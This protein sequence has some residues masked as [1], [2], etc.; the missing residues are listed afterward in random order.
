M[1][2]C[3]WLCP[4]GADY[5]RFV[6]D[7]AQLVADYAR[8]VA[9]F[10]VGKRVDF[11]ARTVIS[12]DPNLRVDQVGVPERVAKI[13]TFPEMVRYCL[14]FQGGGGGW[15]RSA[16]RKGQPISSHSH[17]Y[18]HFVC[19]FRGG[20]WPG[21]DGGTYFMHS[22]PLTLASLQCRDGACR[23]FIDQTGIACTKLT[24]TVIAM[25]LCLVVCDYRA[26]LSGKRHPHGHCCSGCAGPRRV[27]IQFNVQITHPETK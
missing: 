9:P 5:A 24:G 27:E 18:K 3:C 22:Q 12:P 16:Y 11:S 14:S 2:G 7:Y 8:L 10:A 6:V 25:H 4:I 20:G 17:R 1:P 26:R 23:V 15:S 13:M 19:L 21:G